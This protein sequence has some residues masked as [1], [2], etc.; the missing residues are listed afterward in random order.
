[1]EAQQYMSMKD[2]GKL[3]GVSAATVSKWRGRYA[4]TPYPTPEPAAW[5]GDPADGGVPGWKDVGEWKAWKELLPGRGHGGGPLPL[6]AA[7][8]E[9]ERAFTEVGKKAKVAGDRMRMIALSI[10]AAE[11]GV[12]DETIKSVWV[13]IADD[14]PTMPNEEIDKLALAT[15]MRGR[16]RLELTGPSDGET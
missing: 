11:Y 7:L 1:M 9:L 6:N 3:F 2:V 15:I 8:D 10:A 14:N 4:D 13:R 12:D 16:K 5:I